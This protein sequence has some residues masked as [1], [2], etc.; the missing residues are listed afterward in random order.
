MAAPPSE[1]HP[2]GRYAFHSD[3]LEYVFGTL[4][5]RRGAHWRPEDRKLSEQMT[6]YW[7]NF[8][9]TGNPNGEGLPRWSRY[10][11]EKLLLHLDSTI[12]AGPDVARPRYEFLVTI[13]PQER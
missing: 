2:E 4:D 13:P 10:D 7:S 11:K 12:I 6:R 5:R 9:G 1:S 3:E 8:A